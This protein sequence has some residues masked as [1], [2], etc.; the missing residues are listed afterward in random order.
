MACMSKFRRAN[1][2]FRSPA[3]SG[4]SL[5][6]TPDWRWEHTRA[7][8]PCSALVDRPTRTQF[9][10][11]TQTPIRP[12]QPGTEPHRQQFAHGGSWSRCRDHRSEEHTSE[13]QS[14]MRISYAVF[15]LKKKKHHK[16]VNTT[17]I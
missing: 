15:C 12:V 17:N 7:P 1:I 6:W 4:S 5:R 16:T 3:T 11:S 8:A 2:G 10:T 14:L 13:L 9:S